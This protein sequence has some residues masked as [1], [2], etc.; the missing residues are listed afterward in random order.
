MTAPTDPAGGSD[1]VAATVVCCLPKW[2]PRRPL[3][4]TMMANLGYPIITWLKVSLA[5]IGKAL[6]TGAGR[7][8]QD[9]TTRS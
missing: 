2:L 1:S 4:A 7:W 8:T 5:E 9:S 6:R 3:S